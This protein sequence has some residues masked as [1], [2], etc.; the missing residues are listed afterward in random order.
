MSNIILDLDGTLI[1]SYYGEYGNNLIIV[2]RPF[3]RKFLE[4]LFLNHESVSIWTNGSKQWFE[5]CHD[6]CLKYHLPD[7]C[8]FDFIITYDDDLVT[9]KRTCPKY[10]T[11]IYQKYPKYNKENTIMIDDSIHTMQDNMDNGILIP[12]FDFDPDLP[13]ACDYELL[14]TL[15]IIEAL[16]NS[17]I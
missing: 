8:K 13:F 3:L 4:S 17:K 16:V 2:A 1:D 15:A 6:E 7:G 5:R 10:L 12:T 9:C 14:N 11:K